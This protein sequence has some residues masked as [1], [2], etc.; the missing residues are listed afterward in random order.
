MAIMEINIVP[1][2]TGTPS[3]SRYIAQAVKVLKEKG[4]NYEL[5]SM[6]TIVEGKLDD[7]FELAKKMHL[8]TFTQG[9][10]RVVTTIKIDDRRDKSSDMKEKV[11]RVKE[12]L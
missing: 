2:G 3:V 5:T 11:Q 9:I 6:G 12:E 4:V 1:L 8:A 10:K 7:L